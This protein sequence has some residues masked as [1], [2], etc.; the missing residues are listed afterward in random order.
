MQH[1]AHA[2][3]GEALRLLVERERHPLLAVAVLDL[4]RDVLHVLRWVRVLWDLDL[5]AEE[6]AVADRDGAAERLELRPGVLDVVLARHL[7]AR[8]LEHGRQHVAERSAA[9]VRDGERARR[10]RRD[11]FDL[12]PLPSERA[13]AAEITARAHD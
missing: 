13:R 4:L 7:R 12:Q 9:R 5:L 1:P 8:E 6:L 11:E 10:I 2:L 3:V